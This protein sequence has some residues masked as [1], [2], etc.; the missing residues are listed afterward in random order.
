MAQSASAR[1]ALALAG[2][3]A[4]PLAP[5]ETVLQ[6]VITPQIQGLFNGTWNRGNG[7]Q[8]KLA[9]FSGARLNSKCQSTDSRSGWLLCVKLEDLRMSQAICL[10]QGIP[11]L[12]TGKKSGRGNGSRHFSTLCSQGFRRADRCPGHCHRSEENSRLASTPW[13]LRQQKPPEHQSDGERR[14]MP[15]DQKT[16]FDR[17]Y[18]RR[19]IAS[20]PV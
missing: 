16:P 19:G 12:E 15:P 2:Q 7:A 8:N 9:A 3:Q 14:G 11:T 1:S 17:V 13:R 10:H 4:Q 18:F 6:I 5:P 20:S